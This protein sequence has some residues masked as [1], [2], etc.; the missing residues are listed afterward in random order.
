MDPR[1]NQRRDTR[2]EANIPV[3]LHRDRT[4]VRL[5]TVDVSYRG[6]FV[7]TTAELQKRS[8]IRSLVK[9]H[10]ELPTG[11]FGVHAMIVHAHE[12]RLGLGLQFWALNG[13]ERKTW[14]TFV[15]S[16]ID[17]RRVALK[18]AATPVGPDS[19]VS[20]I[21]SVVPAASEPEIAVT[22]QRATRR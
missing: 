20:G 7:E 21:R 1:D 19:Q 9:L 18:A 15:R 3:V 10:V 6:I 22:L 14:E 2:V 11:G 8:A 4:T 12:I 13:V 16:I 5:V 17:A